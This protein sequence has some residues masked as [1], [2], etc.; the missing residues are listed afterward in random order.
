MRDLLTLESDGPDRRT[1]FLVED[2]TS[3][4][5]ASALVSIPQTWTYAG[6]PILAGRPES[7][8]TDKEYRNKGLVRV[9]FEEFHRSS[10][11]RGDLLQG[12]TGIPWFYRQFGYEMAVEF[13]GSRCAYEAQVKPPP[14]LK[15][16]AGQCALP[17]RDDI[18]F[19]HDLYQAS[20]SRYL[21]HAMLSAD[22]WENELFNQHPDSLGKPG[23]F[24]L[25]MGTKTASRIL[26]RFDEEAG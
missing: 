20:G 8:A 22:Q 5:I 1:G 12:I 3:G 24:I 25:R 7:V 26:H 13:G 21:L 16:P 23:I 11:A 4:R 17:V 10:Q 2:E 15:K 14:R 6:I 19:L 9:L 18:P